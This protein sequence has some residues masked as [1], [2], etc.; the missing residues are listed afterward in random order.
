M[1]GLGGCG[2]NAS[3]PQRTLHDQLHAI[4]IYHISRCRGIIDYL[5]EALDGE[6]SCD[7]PIYLLRLHC[8]PGA[9]WQ[10]LNFRIMYVSPSQ[11]KGRTEF[12]GQG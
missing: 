8:R 2:I 12:A 7:L 3:P 10:L 5:D 11:G 1:P 9:P 4:D 6:L